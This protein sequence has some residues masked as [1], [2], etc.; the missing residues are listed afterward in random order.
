MPVVSQDLCCPINLDLLVDPVL[1]SDGHTYSR[2]AIVNYLQQHSIS[3]ITRQAM[4]IRELVP[5]RLIASM[6]EQFSKE[7]QSEETL[8][9]QSS[10]LQKITYQ[11]LVKDHVRQIVSVLEGDTVELVPQHLIVVLDH[12]GSMMSNVDSGAENQGFT[13]WNLV[14]H[15]FYTFLR[16]LTNKHRL[17]LV[18]FNRSAHVKY[19]NVALSSIDI[20]SL[21]KSLEAM[22][23]GGSTDIEQAL[24]TASSLKESSLPNT[25][26]LLTDGDCQIINSL[27]LAKTLGQKIA[28]QNILLHTIG[29][30]N[31]IKSSILHALAHTSGGYFTFIPDKSMIFTVICSVIV[32]VMLQCA[33]KEIPTISFLVQGNTLDVESMPL[34]ILAQVHSVEDTRDYAFRHWFVDFLKECVDLSPM[35]ISLFRQLAAGAPKSNTLT[36][37]AILENLND[38]VRLACTETYYDSW[39]HH[40]L[41]ALHSAHTYQVCTNFKDPSVQI[42][43]TPLF[44]KLMSQVETTFKS[45]KPPNPTGNITQAQ[46]QRV[47]S[48]GGPQVTTFTDSSVPCFTGDSVVYTSDGKRKRVDQVVIGDCLETHLGESA[49]RYIVQT[50]CLQPIKVVMFGDALITTHHPIMFTSNDKDTILPYKTGRPVVE[51]TLPTSVFSFVLDRRDHFILVGDVYAITLGNELK[52]HSHHHPYYG[53]R[54]IVDDLESTPSHGHVLVKNCFFDVDGCVSELVFESAHK[55]YL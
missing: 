47:A 24:L 22:E 52:N 53:S 19:R 17:S 26:L 27:V 50:D 13:R 3:P 16:V 55:N 18:L 23:P 20:D 46:R 37:V 49:V 32:N 7:Q 35:S 30:S 14:I 31:D 15:C 21:I 10:T 39:G 34:E 25:I 41:L 44:N 42:Y 4:S 29:F 28:D 43:R 1:G 5:N 51:I 6:V 48:S 36:A 38:Q 11:L 12:S 2:A 54:L 33:V 9:T 8:F 45:I 40:Y